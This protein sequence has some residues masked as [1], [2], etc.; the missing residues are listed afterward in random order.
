MTSITLHDLNRATDVSLDDMPSLMD[1]VRASIKADAT[2]TYIRVLAFRLAQRH[3][4]HLVKGE[5]TYGE[6]TFV[7]QD[8]ALYLDVS[9]GTVSLWNVLSVAVDR[10]ITP[11]NDDR[12][13]ERFNAIVQHYRKD[14]GKALRAKPYTVKA[15][16]AAIKAAKATD[17][18]QA[19]DRKSDKDKR[20]SN[21]TS[22]DEADA[23]QVDAT[24]SGKAALQAIDAALSDWDRT[25]DAGKATDRQVLAFASLIER[26]YARLHPETSD[27]P[28][29]VDA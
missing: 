12:N 23:P 3:G 6:N 21:A 9:K 13:R 17:T 14:I 26:R 15:V 16:D 18:A 7:A 29:T 28:E 27:Q 4:F 24:P 25:V 8:Y 20:V 2:L 22:P 11:E 5:P 1:E 19:A 10:G